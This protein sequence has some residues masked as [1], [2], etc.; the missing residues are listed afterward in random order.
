MYKNILDFTCISNLIEIFSEVFI[1][2]DFSLNED[3]VVQN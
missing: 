1:I 3:N 2:Y